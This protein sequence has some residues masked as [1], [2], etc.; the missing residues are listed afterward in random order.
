MDTGGSGQEESQVCLYAEST[1]PE[2][3]KRKFWIARCFQELS[4]NGL[5]DFW[6]NSQKGELINGKDGDTLETTEVRIRIH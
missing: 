4:R 1:M 3:R 2:D 6:V 5:S